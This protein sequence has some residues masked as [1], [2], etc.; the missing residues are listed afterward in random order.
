MTRRSVIEAAIQQEFELESVEEGK[1]RYNLR[2]STK[3]K[4]PKS[5]KE[6][7]RLTEAATLKLAFALARNN[8][9]MQVTDS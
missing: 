3:N 5:K 8:V 6:S 7:L 1:S 2:N 9:W 4:A